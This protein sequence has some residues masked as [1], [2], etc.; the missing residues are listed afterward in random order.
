ME[1]TECIIDA[2]SVYSLH[3][4][5]HWHLPIAQLDHKE[6]DPM[7]DPYIAEVKIFAGNFA[8]RNWAFCNGQLLPISSNTAL[9]TDQADEQVFCSYIIVA[10]ALSF[11][12][13]QAKHSTRSLCKS[14]HTR[15]DVPPIC[16]NKNS[17]QSSVE[18]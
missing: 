4:R 18:R 13:G 16:I 7:S 1:Y 17:R 8:P 6:T 10:H 14:L 9:F 12:V 2:V 11:L 15:Q 5:A 3:H